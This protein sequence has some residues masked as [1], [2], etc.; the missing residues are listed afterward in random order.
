VVSYNTISD[1]GDGISTD[2]PPYKISY[3]LDIH[4]N[5]ITRVVDDLI[6]IDGSI[7]NT[8][9]YKNR[10]YNGRMGVSVA[11]VYGGPAYIFRNEFYNLEYSTIKMN[12]KPAGLV[13]V[14]N[15][16]V[17]L[18]RGLTSNSG[19]QNTIF[20]NN[21]VLSGHYVMEEY[22]LVA[23]SNDDWNYNGYHSQRAGI[24]A[25]PWFKW[26]NIKYNNIGA[27]TASGVTEANSRAIDYADFITLS[28]PTAY[29]IEAL[30]SNQ[31]F[32]PTSNSNLIDAG[33]PFDN[34]NIKDGITG[35]PDIGAYEFGQT[36]PHYGHDF[37]TVC[38][39]INLATRTWNGSVSKGWYD[40]KNWTPCGIPSTFTVVTIPGGLSKYPFVNTDT[41]IGDL[42]LTGNGKLDLANDTVFKIGE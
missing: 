24:S 16:A 7:S 3:A 21:A 30:P 23:G 40:P 29:A 1:F 26:N 42:F 8:R 6:E 4:H 37:A 38:D 10:C 27:L 32:L 19:W 31:N 2:G 28:T 17:K 18:D 5:D 14:N 34:L 11:P 33:V 41:F 36:T 15:S 35:L 25:G 22:G 39:R 9:V 13:I 12:R 20:K